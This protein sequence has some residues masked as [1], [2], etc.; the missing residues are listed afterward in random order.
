M[1]K[2]EHRPVRYGEDRI[3]I[4]GTVPGIGT[5][6]DDPDGWV[7]ALLESLDGTRTVD[8]V[9]ADLVHR[10][11]THPAADVREAIDDL[12]TAGY[13]HEPEPITSGGR[14]QSALA[15]WRWIDRTPGR[16]AQD[17][18][19]LLAQ[20]RVTVIGVGGVGATAALALTLAGVGQIHCV[21]DDVVELSNLNRQILYTENDLGLPKVQAAVQ[22][23]REHNS[24]VRVTGG[25][26]RVDG[27]AMLRAL[28]TECDVLLMAADTPSE[29]RFWTA[30]ACQD[31]GTAW[32]HGGYEG[33]RVSVGLYRPGTGP[34]HD[35][36][37]IARQHEL[38]AGPAVTFWSPGAGRT[39]AHASNVITAVTTGV[40]AAHVTMSLITGAPAVP[41]N[42]EF[43]WNLVRL[44][45]GQRVGL[46]S[47][48]PACPTCG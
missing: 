9:V 20:A 4:G 3:V 46:D 19:M 44:D 18:Q 34:C 28:A 47:P 35:C 14:H 40:H 15:L 22:R 8:Q 31:T 39:R 45:Q 43:G 12:H 25:F 38:A 7:W 33:P 21:D 16:S 23:L 2:F 17:V 37:Q 42:G 41:A 36:G 10:Y 26:Q 48:L 32:V 24:E 30:A 27:T 1:I 29:I 5:E 13:L 6:I 11:P